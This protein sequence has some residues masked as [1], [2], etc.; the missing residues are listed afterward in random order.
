MVA[1]ISL[2]YISCYLINA[3]LVCKDDNSSYLDN[4]IFNISFN[5]SCICWISHNIFSNFYLELLSWSSSLY[6]PRIGFIFVF[7][8]PLMNWWCCSACFLYS[9]FVVL[10]IFL[11]FLIGLFAFRCIFFFLGHR[12]GMLLWPYSWQLYNLFQQEFTD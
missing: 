4:I 2:L 10:Y 5:M 11:L 9:Y 6:N 3:F 7:C 1:I 12:Q 8:T